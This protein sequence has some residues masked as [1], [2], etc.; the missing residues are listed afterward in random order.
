MDSADKILKPGKKNPCN[1]IR[2]AIFMTELPPLLKQLNKICKDNFDK[3]YNEFCQEKDKFSKT[4]FLYARPIDTSP[5]YI[6]EVHFNSWL[7][8]DGTEEVEYGRDVP[9]ESFFR[10][11]EY[12][13]VDYI[14]D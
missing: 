11:Y 13:F 9:I 7:S 8:G 6:I 3:F 2:A 1:G 12:E 4:E 10:L 5:C 14:V